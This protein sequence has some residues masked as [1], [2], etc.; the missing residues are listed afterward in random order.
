MIQDWDLD[1]D[2]K[3]ETLRLMFGVPRGWLA[4]GQSV[5]I[6]NAATTFG[7]MSC[8]VKSRLNKGLVDVLVTPPRIAAKAMLLRAPVPDGWKVKSVQIGDETLPLIDGDTVDLSGRTDPM[9][10]RFRVEPL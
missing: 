8:E 7:V 5:H 9:L 1:N 6:R 4:D 10:V 2:A 3:P